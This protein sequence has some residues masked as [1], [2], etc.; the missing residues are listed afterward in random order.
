MLNEWKDLNLWLVSVRG[1]GA[2]GKLS[3]LDLNMG[4]HVRFDATTLTPTNTRKYWLANL[5]ANIR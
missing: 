2:D 5:A 1:D 3:G 4:S